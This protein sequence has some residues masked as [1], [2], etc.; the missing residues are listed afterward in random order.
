LTHRPQTPL[1]QWEARVWIFGVIAAITIAVITG[2]LHRA[3]MASWML[4]LIVGGLV[5]AMAAAAAIAIHHAYDHQVRM[6]DEA[7]SVR[8]RF[9]QWLDWLPRNDP[10]KAETRPA[11]SEGND[12]PLS[13]Q[14]LI[15]IAMI[16]DR[17]R[18]EALRLQ[19]ERAEA[20]AVL[21]NLDGGVIA[22]DPRSRITLINAAAKKFFQIDRPCLGQPLIQSIRQPEIIETVQRVMRDRSTR[23]VHVEIRNDEGQRR[24]LRLRCCSLRYG[25][26]A[27]V[28]LAAHDESETKHSE[29]VRRE[30]VAN[31]SHELKTPLAA[32]KGYAET[33][34]LA[35]ND[36]PEAAKHFVSQIHDQCKRLERLIAD[37]MT[38]ARAQ[39][40]IQHLRPTTVD[41]DEVIAES[42][43]TYAPV[44]AAR[45]ITLTHG[46]QERPTMVYA[47]REATLTIA[48]NVIGNAIRYT[49]EGGAVNATAR[50]EGNFGV[51]SVQDNGIGIPENEQKRI[52]ERFYRVDRSRKHASSGTGL[53]LSIVKNLTQS[54]GGEIKLRSRQG[55]G[56]TFEIL[57][58]TQSANEADLTQ[59]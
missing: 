10:T 47:D 53:G 16:S 11:A 58:P 22:L 33:V 31:V 13:P 55:E 46:K 12:L 48:N 35:L 5:F 25:E 30:F 6:Q 3:E 49:P 8:G 28:L 44:A 20:N 39:A 19:H 17:V 18:S 51:L 36:D 45:Q 54:Q 52:F 38:L 40:G 15:E 26:V 9:K 50:S 42:I 34:E 29:E 7:E 43:A 1:A 56:S 27:G 32:I 59:H 37:M 2:L 4:A 23:E 41:L 21:A 57:L 24:S 14:S